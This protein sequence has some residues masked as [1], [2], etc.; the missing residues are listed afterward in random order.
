M[1]LTARIVRTRLGMAV[2]VEPAR[3]GTAPT[4]LQPTVD[5][6]LSIVR[7]AL[8]DGLSLEGTDPP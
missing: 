6:L 5:E 7:Y 8:S 4:L 2:V 3:L 1:V